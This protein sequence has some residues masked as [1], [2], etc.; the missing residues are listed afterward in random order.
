MAL[1]KLS[2]EYAE[3]LKTLSAMSK[4]NNYK[5]LNTDS[6]MSRTSPLRL[7]EN[8]EFHT[9]FKDFIKQAQQIQKVNRMLI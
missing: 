2:F 3:K 7:A 4:L 9:Q 1:V 6:S 5:K 8:S